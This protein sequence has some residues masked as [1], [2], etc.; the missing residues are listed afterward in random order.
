MRPEARAAI[1]CRVAS[2]PNTLDTHGVRGLCSAHYARLKNWGSLREDLPIQSQKPVEI[3]FWTQIEESPTG[4]WLWQGSVNDQGY[5][6]VGTGGSA[7]GT[8]A[9]AHRWCYEYMI[10]EVPEGLV[11]DHVVCNTPRCVNPY[12][13][14]PVTL[15]VNTARAHALGVHKAAQEAKRTKPTCKRGHRLEGENLYLPPNGLQRVCK[16]CRLATDRRYKARQRA[17]VSA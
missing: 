17:K 12:H 5:G 1:P 8:R 6:R 15:A 7:G 2:C 16:T 9:L 14:E 13:L 3:R 10:G 4:C 11:L